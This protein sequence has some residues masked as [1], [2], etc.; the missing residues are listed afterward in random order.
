MTRPLG[1][2]GVPSSAGAYAPGQEQ[3]PH[4][5]RDAGLLPQLEAAGFAIIDHHDAPIWRWTPDRESPRAQNAEVVAA[6][7]AATAERVR[8]ALAA[9]DWPLV[10]GGDCTV[11]VGTFAGHLD[12]EG[13][14]GLVYLDLHADLNTPDTVV[15]G[16]L[17]W[18]GVAHLLGEESATP[19]LR[20]FGPRMPLLDDDQIVLLGFDAA[21]ATAGERERV[22]RRGLAVVPVEAV[23]ADPAGA[24]AKAL[25]HLAGCDRLVVHFDVD[26]IDFTDAPLSENTG[27]GTGVTQDQAFAALSAVLADPRVSALTI[28]ELNPYHGAE[29]GTTLTIFVENLVAA[30][31][32]V[33]ALAPSPARTHG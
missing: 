20:D 19:G 30:L 8:V 7:A 9:G 5:L 12:D 31:A 28:T 16:A 3:A 14:A 15:D 11:G 17:D 26:V 6:C 4:A 1:V 23:A 32:A 33:Q 27:R 24:A 29:D 21:H 22:E 10:L 25:S 18:M 13:R 2:I